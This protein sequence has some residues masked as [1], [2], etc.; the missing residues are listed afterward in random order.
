MF[1]LRRGT[2]SVVL[3]RML[4]A[5]IAEMAKMAGREAEKV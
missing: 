1:S 2:T 5:S 3:S 4:R